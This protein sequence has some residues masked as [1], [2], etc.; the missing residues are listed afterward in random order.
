MSGPVLIVDGFLDLAARSQLLRAFEPLGVGERVALSTVHVPQALEER[1]KDILLRTANGGCSPSSPFSLDG[2]SSG[3]SLL[4]PMPGR[5]AVGAS[6]M[7]QDT[8]FDEDGVPDPT[9]VEDYVLVLY[10]D[11]SGTLVVDSGSGEH[12]IPIQP[13]RLIAWPNQSCHHRIDV[14]DGSP[15]IMIG[16]MTLTNDTWK[17]AGDQYAV[18]DEIHP[19]WREEARARAAAKAEAEAAAPKK[20]LNITA[21]KADDGCLEITCTGMGGD[22][23]VLRMPA[24]STVKQ[25]WELIAKEADV[26]VKQLKLLYCSKELENAD[27]AELAQEYFPELKVSMLTKGVKTC[28][29]VAD[30][31]KDGFL[32]KD[33]LKA[34]ILDI[35]EKKCISEDELEA[36]FKSVD[37]NADGKLSYE[38]FIDWCFELKLISEEVMLHAYA[39]DA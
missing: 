29:T 9:I 13:G 28:F 22:V 12:A 39:D 14:S 37:Q 3:G 31:N 19:G 23:G 30:T 10:L 33:E 32:S 36:A 17:R 2:S 15:R 1:F 8:G 6:P 21:K 34:I 18:W 35:D 38:E 24:T 7:H 5:V 11:G 20:V 27:S 25:F 4:V 26:P 16:P